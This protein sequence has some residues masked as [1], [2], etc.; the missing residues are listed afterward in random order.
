MPF[1]KLHANAF[2]QLLREQ[3]PFAMLSPIFDLTGVTMVTPA[4][5]VQLAAACYALA[6]VQ[7][8][9]TIVID[10]SNVRSYLSRAGFFAAVEGVASI[11]SPLARS[12]ILLYERLRGSN[13]MLIEVTKIENGKY[14]PHLLDQVVWVLRNKFKYL[15]NDAFDVAT[16]VSEICQNTFDHNNNTAFG[17][18]AMQVY[19]KGSKRFLEIAVADHGDGLAKT[20]RRNPKVE[21]IDTDIK[22]IKLATTMGISEYDDPTRGTGLYHI[23]QIAYKHQGSVRIR[24]GEAKV[25]FRMQE[26]RG[27]AN[28]VAYLKGVQV[29]FSLPAR[30]R[31]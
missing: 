28:R 27:W 7:K 23:L 11:A 15:K 30:S 25:N 13:P 1:T 24:S 9:P 22:A 10:D 14:L 6:E 26:K 31:S 21:F 2:D 18:L 3:D 5:L 17:F 4:G 20:L 29:S 19:G 8:R 16:A 12:D